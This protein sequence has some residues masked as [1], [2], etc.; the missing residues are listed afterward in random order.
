MKR[1]AV[2]TT[3]RV[4]TRKSA[5]DR[6]PGPCRKFERGEARTRG[7]PK[8]RYENS[9]VCPRVLIQ[10][11]ENVPPRGERPNELNPG[12]PTH[13]DLLDGFISGLRRRLGPAANSQHRLVEGG[14]RGR[15]IHRGDGHAQLRQLGRAELPV[16]QMRAD[17]EAADAPGGL[18]R[19]LDMLE[20]HDFDSREHRGAM[21]P[22]HQ[23]QLGEPLPEVREDLAFDRLALRRRLFRERRRE[24]FSHSTHAWPMQ[25][26]PGSSEKGAKAQSR[27]DP[28]PFAKQ[29]RAPEARS[30]QCIDETQ[31]ERPRRLGP[32]RRGPLRRVPLR[33]CAGR[34]RKPRTAAISSLAMSRGVERGNQLRP[35]IRRFENIR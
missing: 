3:V 31:A 30:Q 34:R 29:N 17:H 5:K 25:T 21:A 35:E 6:G 26:S 20:S 18:R 28:R 32:V 14:M 16:P 23:K 33:R 4:T 27:L 15:P 2:M 1:Q 8:K 19:R 9:F 24:L 13:G 12:P 22:G 11:R 7:T 10:E